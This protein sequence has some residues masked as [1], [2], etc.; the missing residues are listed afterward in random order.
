MGF[1]ITGE[2]NGAAVQHQL[3][4]YPNPG[5][6]TWVV[7]GFNGYGGMMAHAT[8]VHFDGTNYDTIADAPTP[9][10]IHGG[11][12]TITGTYV[13]GT[14]AHM[15]GGWPGEPYD[16]SG[17]APAYLGGVEMHLDDNNV[18]LAIE[19]ACIIGW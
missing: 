15:V 2:T 4:V 16:I 18:A 10:G 11:A 6:G 12:A 3:V 8:I 1:T 7:G 14:S 17:P 9:S 5:D 13:V 19:W